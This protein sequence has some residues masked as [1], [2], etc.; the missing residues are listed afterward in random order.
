MTPN[1]ALERTVKHRG[2]R[3][4]AARH[5][6]RPLNSVVRHGI[7][8]M[9]RRTRCQRGRSVSVAAENASSE[10][11]IAASRHRDRRLENLEGES[12]LGEQ[13]ADVVISA[14][15]GDVVSA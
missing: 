7:G 12:F 5:R 14:F 4:A 3:L 9:S 8:R 10:V 15:R 2:P 6:G 11:A 1:N 13:L